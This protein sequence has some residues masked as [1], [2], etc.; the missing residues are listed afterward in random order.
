MAFPKQFSSHVWL[1]VAAS[2]F[3]LVFP[4][5][6]AFRPR[7]LSAI[8]EVTLPKTFPGKEER[9]EQEHGT[10]RA[11]LRLRGGGVGGIFLS[12]LRAAVKNPV[13]ILC[14]CILYPVTTSGST[15]FSQHILFLIVMGLSSSVVYFQRK[16]PYARHLQSFLQLLI[17]CYFFYL[18]TIWQKMQQEAAD[19]S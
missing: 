19:A 9:H 15:S 18:L 8:V 11:S 1:F 13:L 2:Y 5:V 3:M 17:V 10:V 16:N 4:E 6:G 14:T 12:L 7:S